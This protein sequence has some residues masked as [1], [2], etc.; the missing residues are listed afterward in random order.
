MFVGI[1]DVSG[2]F[3]CRLFT[4]D[5]DGSGVGSRSRVP[6]FKVGC[7]PFETST[8]ITHNHEPDARNPQPCKPPTVD[9]NYRQ[10]TQHQP[11]TFVVSIAD[12]VNG[13]GVHCTSPCIPESY[14]IACIARAKIISYM[15]RCLSSHLPHSKLHCTVLPANTFL[16]SYPA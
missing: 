1:I 4:D 11:C 3:A 15:L 5:E 10:A 2:C 16:N 9:D 14:A 6:L 12:H 13:G 8:M 7:N